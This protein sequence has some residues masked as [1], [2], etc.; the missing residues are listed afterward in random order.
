MTVLVTGASGFIGRRLCESLR[1]DHI[2]FRGVQKNATGNACYVVGN[3][4]DTGSLAQACIGVDTVFHCAGYAH[5]FSSLNEDD[6]ALHWQINFEG[7]QNLLRACADAGVSRFI[8]LSSVKAMAEPGDLCVDE[9]F[10]GEP[11]TAYGKSKLAAENAVLEAGHRYGMHV[12]NLRLSMVYGS[13]GRGNLE[14]MGRLVK[15]GLFPP[16]PETGNHRSMVHV[17]D[18]VS[19]VRLAAGD[20]R[21]HGRTY[22]VAG[23]EAPSGRELFDALRLAQGM[24]RIDWSIPASFMRGAG[25]LS[26]VMETL[27]GR[28]L[29][30]NGEV[31][32]RL[33]N[34]AWYSP[35]LIGHELGWQ[36]KVSLSDGLREMLSE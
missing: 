24:P 7:T 31:L 2:A 20:D 16:L 10:A 19:A 28:R 14:R 23:V 29:P 8:F 34:S 36:P 5:A 22:I 27:I 18:V 3:L 17:S 11:D 4:C 25:R 15:Q 26:D 9:T 6:A 32:D 30:F 1:E 21:A 13:G 12:V 35:K 33:L